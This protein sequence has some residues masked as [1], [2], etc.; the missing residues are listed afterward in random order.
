MKTIIRDLGL[1]AIVAAGTGLGLAAPAVADDAMAAAAERVAQV[2]ATDPAVDEPIELVEATR[3]RH[4]RLLF[5]EDDLDELRERAENEGRAFF[6]HLASYGGPPPARDAVEFQ[7]NA[8]DGQRQGLW[9]MPSVALH[10]AI[11]G[12]QRSFDRALGFLELMLELD[13]WEVGGEADSGMSHGNLMAGVAL[14][15]DVLYNDL[16]P[17][18]REQVRA[19]LLEH[20]RRQYYLGHQ[21]I[22]GGPG[23]W[24]GD[25]H[26]NHRWH[27]NVGLMLAAIAIAEPD[28]EDHHWILEKAAEDLAYVMAWMPEDGTSHESPSYLV[29]GGVH[30]TLAVDAADRNLGTDHFEHP[31]FRNTL[32]F[33]VYTASP[34]FEKSF[35]YGD[36]TE[37]TFGGYSNYHYKAAAIAGDPDYQD[38]I[39]RLHEQNPGSAWLGWLSLLWYDPGLE[40]GSVENLP[41]AHYFPDIGLASV[42][43]GWESQNV[44]AVF[45]N[46]PYGGHKLN[47]FR[48]ERDY[49]YVNVAHD[50]ADANSFMIYA[51]GQML[52]KPDG[53]SRD[54]LSAAQNTILV[55]G[56][57]QINEGGVWTQPVRNRDMTEL[58]RATTY[59]LG[60]DGTLVY[61]GESG[62]S[63]DGIDRFRRAM[64]WVPGRYILIFDDI[65][66]SEANEIDWLVQS[67]SAEVL[68]DGRY[69]LVSGDEAL[70]FVA[71]GSQPLSAAVVDS[72]AQHRGNS[73]GYEQVRLSAEA[74][75]LTIAAAFDPW[76]HGVLD[77]SLDHDGPD[78]AVITVAGPGFVDTWSWQAAQG[79]WTPATF[80]AEHNGEVFIEVG[81]EDQ[82]PLE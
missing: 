82:A 50:D 62:P 59:K 52:T 46:Y 79:L 64:I 67:E 35:A 73:L 74:D 51:R 39:V 54:K 23:Y 2:P 41:L 27:R 77:V 43:D 31:F 47:H 26:N 10:Y 68:S 38:A 55:N 40:R 58:T 56:Q 30:L 60:E 13:H 21:N 14:I 37:G 61:E 63:Y 15:Y 25:T 65:R 11:T 29:F 44:A 12:E 72:P 76:Q 4:P 16:A 1:M 3:G 19:K 17:A 80:T 28:R 45:L 70:D 49:Q 71:T 81:P 24:Q 57:G 22:A 33:R 20:A 18:F 5:T 42:R 9:R 53:Y 32:A 69:R 78:A 75:V 34:G 7:T 8:T 6:E 36:S 66:G 48:N